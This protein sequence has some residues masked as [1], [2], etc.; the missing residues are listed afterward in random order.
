MANRGW[1]RLN[2]NPIST[3]PKENNNIL[4]SVERRVGKAGGFTLL[5]VKMVL[6]AMIVNGHHLRVPGNH[7]VG[8]IHMVEGADR[9]MMRIRIDD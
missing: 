8:Q 2:N 4:G 1:K 6:W 3:I 7:Q 9:V 5:Y